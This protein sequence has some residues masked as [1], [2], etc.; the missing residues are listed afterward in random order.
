[1]TERGDPEGPRP[2]L[3]SG[4]L[5]RTLVDHIPA[6]VGY[7]DEDLRNVLANTAYVEWFGM[8]P[9]EMAG[10]HIREVIGPDLFEKNL[11]HIVAALAGQAQMFDR[12]IV[13]AAGVLRFSQAHY[14]P[15]IDERGRVRGFFVLVVDVS[16][17]V[18][19]ERALAAAHAEM[20][21][22]AT[23]DPLTGLANR[24][25]LEE[26]LQHAAMGRDRSGRT[27]ALLIIDLDHFKPVNDAYGHAAGDAMLIEVATRLRTTVRGG[28]LVARVGGDEFVVLCPDIGG[29]D[30]AADLADRLVRVLGVDIQVPEAEAPLGV[31]ASIGVVVTGSSGAL[32]SAALMREADH[33]MYAAKH[34]G[35][36]R[37]VGGPVLPA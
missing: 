19:A 16:A 13:D 24:A 12:E 18:T 6:M 34:A 9:D 4:R 33:R 3:D 27:I 7:W 5:L 28:D 35:G 26:R 17:R 20:A 23:T 2:G 31:G 37:W 29:S 14:M 8:S 36:G 11:R 15:D 21:L 25:L 1:V 32:P 22:R 10:R 30:E